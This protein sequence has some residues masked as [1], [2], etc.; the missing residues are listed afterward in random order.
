LEKEKLGK[1]LSTLE[2]KAKEVEAALG[3]SNTRR[4]VAT[5]VRERS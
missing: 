4:T 5:R 1:E 3:E 2:A